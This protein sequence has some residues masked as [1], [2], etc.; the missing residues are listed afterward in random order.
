MLLCFF[1]LT[2]VKIRYFQKF[3]FSSK[4]FYLTS[5]GNLIM[6]FNWIFSILYFQFYQYEAKNH[7]SG[8]ICIPSSYNS[9]DTPLQ[10]QTNNVKV[11]IPFLQ[12]L[13]VNDFDCTIKMSFWISVEW[14]EPR[15][16]SSQLYSIDVYL[17]KLDIYICFKKMIC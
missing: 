12:I 8:E 16:E 10:N 2:W 1:H 13:K 4:I 11:S 17:K 7:C 6:K 9:L 5:V 14:I 15:W 3:L